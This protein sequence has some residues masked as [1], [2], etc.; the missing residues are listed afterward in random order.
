MFRL[1]EYSRAACHW[2]VKHEDIVKKCKC[3]AVNSPRYRKMV[4]DSENRVNLKKKRFFRRFLEY[5]R[6]SDGKFNHK[7][8][9]NATS[10]LFVKKGARMCS[11]FKGKIF[12][13]LCFLKSLQV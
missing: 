10:D 1:N 8:T 3:N 7:K 12:V 9:K 11:P 13:Y 4:F 2:A 5:D 6:K